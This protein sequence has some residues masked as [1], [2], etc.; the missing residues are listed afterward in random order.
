MGY[1]IKNGDDQMAKKRE[2][3]TLR[4]RKFAQQEFLKLKKMQNGELDAGPKPSEVA[5]TLTFSEKIK[6][7][8][9]HDKMAIIIIASLVVA[10]SLLVVSCATKPKYD[11]TIVLYNYTFTGD[12]ICDR[13]EEYLAQFCEDFNGDGKVNVNVINYSLSGSENTEANYRNRLALQ[14]VQAENQNVILYITD[15]LSFKEQNTKITFFEEEPIKLTDDFY[16]YCTDDSGFFTTPKGL[17][18]SCRV[19]KGTAIENK[20]DVDIYYQQA[21][22]ILKNLSEH[23]ANQ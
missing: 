14:T 16:S 17:Q 20:K 4:Q 11:A 2:S 1:N 12:P 22:T 3:D 8:W 18:I 5:A 10:I 15:D 13:M 6:N 9:Y 21:Q 23:N 7:I 19:I